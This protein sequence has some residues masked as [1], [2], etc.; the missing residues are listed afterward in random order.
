MDIHTTPEQLNET[1]LSFTTAAC[2]YR[3]EKL[4]QTGEI[5]FFFSYVKISH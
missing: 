2:L 3:V 4:R 5:A 1:F